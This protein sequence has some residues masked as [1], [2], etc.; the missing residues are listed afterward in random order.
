MLIFALFEETSPNANEFE[1]EVRALS[2]A[3]YADLYRYAAF[4]NVDPVATSFYEMIVFYANA[5]AR[6][7][8][9]GLD[10]RNTTDVLGAMFNATYATPRGTNVTFDHIGDRV[11]TYVIKDFDINQEDFKVCT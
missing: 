6:V 10:V 5:V 8:D 7:L 3:K 11:S 2:R 4:E 1:N 9:R